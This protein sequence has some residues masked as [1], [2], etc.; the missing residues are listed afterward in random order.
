M[1]LLN[2]D[3][4]FQA[5]AAD[6]LKAN[7][8]KYGGSID[9]MEAMMPEV[10]IAW[11]NLPADWLEGQTP[12]AYFARFDDVAVLMDWMRAYF[13]GGVPVPD[14]LLERITALGEAAEE[15]LVALLDDEAAPNDARLTAIGMLMEM[16]SSRPLDRY[17]RWIASRAEHDERAELAAEALAAMGGQV[18]DPVLAAV[19][20]ATPSGVET[21]A[22][23]LSNFPGVLAAFDLTLKLFHAEKEKRA[24]YGSLLGKLGDGR[25]APALLAALEDPELNYLDYIEL[26]NALEAVGGDAPP[27]RSFEGD[28]YYESLKRMD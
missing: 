26:R 21:F 25:A 18:V 10:Y 23:V 5:Y 14:Q 24:L 17:V 9:R 28:A 27:E 2:F 15:A 1:T 11:L 22:D 4:R 12:G 3:E 20:E 16:Q 6:W 7:A 13:Q 8:A 19:T